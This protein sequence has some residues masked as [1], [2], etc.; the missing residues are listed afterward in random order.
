MGVTFPKCIDGVVKSA[1][2]CNATMTHTAV[3]SK[4]VGEGLKFPES[5]IG[6][7]QGQESSLE[8]PLHCSVMVTTV[9]GCFYVYK[10][11][12]GTEEQEPTLRSKS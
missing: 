6:V 11:I 4:Y 3:V 9:P 8:K 1:P 2:V 5:N 12:Q 7:M 10:Q